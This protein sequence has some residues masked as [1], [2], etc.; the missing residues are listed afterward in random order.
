MFRTARAY[1]AGAF[2]F[3]AGQWV[4][5]PL[6]TISYDFVGMDHHILA[7]GAYQAQGPGI[8]TVVGQLDFN[9]KGTGYTDIGI[10]LYVNN[11]L[12]TQQQRSVSNQPAVSETLIVID[13]FKAGDGD[14]IAL[15]GYASQA[16]TL[17]ASPGYQANY[18]SVI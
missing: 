17:R 10:A 9:V 18:L 16:I 12:V 11:T 14:L 1:R 2:S 15:W 8:R 4:M 6:D 13:Q 5:V 3:A 7:N